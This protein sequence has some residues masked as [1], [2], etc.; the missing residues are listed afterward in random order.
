MR[1]SGPSGI[2]RA[3]SKSWGRTDA[4]VSVWCVPL[5]GAATAERSLASH[6]ALRLILAAFTG[7][8]PRTIRFSTGERGKPYLAGGPQFSLSHS[9]HTALIAVTWSGPVGVDVER[10]RPDLN[11]AAFARGIV[12][13]PDVARIE[14]L[15]PHRQ[16]DAW[17][18]AW[19]RLEAVA[20]ASGA[21]LCVADESLGRSNFET[22]D[23]ELDDQYVGA[24]AATP[25]AG[26]IVYHDFR[27]LS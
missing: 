20:K 3:I 19:T 12:P 8:D 4:V 27:L 16:V 13:A 17:F 11:I 26:P 5:R 23:L 10:V 9:D 18:R 7:Q 22:W 6:S 24:V 25:S 2:R 1:P 21:G 15:P 14:A